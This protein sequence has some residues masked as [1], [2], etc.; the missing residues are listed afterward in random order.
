MAWYP[1]PSLR[2]SPAHLLTEQFLA[3]PGP[4]HALH[5]H[6]QSLCCHKQHG[7]SGLVSLLVGVL[8][9]PGTLGR[10]R[11]G[12]AASAGGHS[13]L[14]AGVLGRYGLDDVAWLGEDAGGCQLLESLLCVPCG[15]HRRPDAP[16]KLLA[17]VEG[18]RD[19]V[20]LPEEDTDRVS[21]LPWHQTGDGW[22]R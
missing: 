22:S 11:Q 9:V 20:D 14:G 12:S 13:A 19:L 7:P 6:P 21:T 18:E 15:P 10:G 5:S 3:L 17:A 8:V 2:A 4:G 16:L 1:L